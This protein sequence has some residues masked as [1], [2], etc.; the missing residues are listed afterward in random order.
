MTGRVET[1]ALRGRVLGLLVIRD[2]KVR[3]V[4]SVL[5]YL[6]TVLEPLM[7]AGVYFVV[8]QIIIGRD[9]GEEPYIVFLLAAMLPWQW[10]NGVIHEASKALT[11]EA[12]LVRSAGLPRQ[13]WVLRVV[14]SKFLEYMFALPILA[15]FIIVMPDARHVSWHV[16]ID[17]PLAILIQATLI[18]G[19][20]L[21]L[22]PLSVLYRDMIRIVRVVTR[23]LFYFSPII[24]SA[25]IIQDRMKGL[26]EFF[27]YNPF[28]GIFEL[29][30]RPIFPDAFLG[31][32]PV[33]ISAGVAIVFLGIGM[34]VFR[35]LEGTVLKEI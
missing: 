5:G 1:L 6:W 31:W 7:M 34:W 11:G 20:A 23:L 4:G 14:G 15:A 26:Y 9:V 35:R 2:L 30:R 12:K 24:Y 16:I 27:A 8:F 13:I 32:Q 18:L 25:S 22:A 19:I 10:A 17:Y 3:Y 29:Y 33:L 21:A 28:V